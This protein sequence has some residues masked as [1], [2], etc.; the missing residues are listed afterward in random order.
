M[1]ITRPRVLKWAPIVEA[2]LARASSP[3]PRDLILA[4][5]DVES[6]GKTGLVNPKSGASG[7][8]QVMPGTL[9]DY[10]KRNPN[11]TVS[12]AELRSSSAEA[13]VKQIRVGISVISNFWRGAYNYLSERWGQVPIDELSRIADLFYVAGPG[14]TRER[15]NTME[16]PTWAAIQSRFP[17]WNALPHPRNVFELIEGLAWPTQDIAAW[18]DTP[19]PGQSQGLIKTPKQGLILSML[20]ILAAWWMMKGK[21]G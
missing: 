9:D 3:L 19:A 4:L 11:Q 2:E 17:K 12:L 8:M 18:L 21:K 15:L 14:A 7:L 5:I 1:P 10:N 20:A 13:A 16:N 6:R